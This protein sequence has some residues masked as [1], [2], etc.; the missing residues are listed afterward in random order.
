[1]C[2]HRLNPLPNAV[3]RADLPNDRR[4]PRLNLPSD[5]HVTTSNLR[6]LFAAL[7]LA[8]VWLCASAEELVSGRLAFI[9]DD[10]EYP[11]HRSLCQALLRKQ[12]PPET[13]KSSD[14]PNEYGDAHCAGT[15][16]DGRDGYDQFATD[17][18]RRVCPANSNARMGEPLATR[19]CECADQFVAKGAA[20][21]DAKSRVATATQKIEPEACG[22]DKPQQ[23]AIAKILG[24][25]FSTIPQFRSAWIAAVKPD[26]AAAVAQLTARPDTNR[27]NRKAY[28]DGTRRRFWA[29]V[30]DDRKPGGAYELL[31]LAGAAIAKR[32]NAPILSINGKPQGLDI[33]HVVGLAEDPTKMLSVDN[34]QLSPARENRQALEAIARNDP[35]YDPQKWLQTLAPTCPVPMPGSPS[36]PVQF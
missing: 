16:K 27:A 10:K 14:P 1:V 18:Y 6:A 34:L 20:C 26:D 30:Y 33:D 4:Q 11:D 13:Y 36:M 5:A 9:Y 17:V 7:L 35:F 29:N 25:Q 15:Q 31:T 8:N 22:I 21:L 12:D 28:F 19:R 2:I 3:V 24:K 32:G 23:Q